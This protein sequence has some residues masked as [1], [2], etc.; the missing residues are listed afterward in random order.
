M[1]NTWQKLFG[2]KRRAKD[3]KLLLE[4]ENS[5]SWEDIARLEREVNARIDDHITNPHLQKEDFEKVADRIAK[6][7]GRPIK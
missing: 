5:I 2:A 3:R 6:A 7:F 1:A 4:V